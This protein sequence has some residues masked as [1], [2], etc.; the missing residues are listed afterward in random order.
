[1]HRGNA[2]HEWI[3]VQYYTLQD[4]GKLRAAMELPTRFL[5]GVTKHLAPLVMGAWTDS[6]A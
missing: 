6:A 3:G 4:K 2:A 5:T 1:M